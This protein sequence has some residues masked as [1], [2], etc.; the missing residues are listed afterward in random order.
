MS[1]LKIAFSGIKWNFSV[2]M[3]RVIFQLLQISLLTRFL[4]KEDFGLVAMALF[5]VQFS[6]I[7]VDMGMTPAILNRQNSTKN[8]YSSIYWLNIFIALIIYGVLFFTAPL[9]AV[10]YQEPELYNVIPILGVNVLLIAIG[11]QHRAILQKEFKFKL[12]ALIEMFSYFIGLI[13]ALLLVLNDYGLYSLV[14]STLL[15]SFIANSL[16][17]FYNFKL[18]PISLHFKF[19]ETKPFL[20]VGGYSMGSTILDFFSREFD[21]LI[22]GKML[23]TESLGVYSLSKQIVI[24]VISLVNPLVISVL[25]P[26]LASIQNEKEKI[27]SSYL[28]VVR[29]L[30][31]INFPIYLFIIVFSKE[32]LFTVYGSEYTEAYPILSFLAFTYCMSAISNPVGSLQIATGRTDIGFKWT[33]LRA[34]ITPIFIYIGALVNLTMV[35][36][37]YALLSL[38]FIIPLWFIQLRPMAS[39]QLKE[40]INQF[41]KPFLFLI[42]VIIFYY[43]FEENTLSN[44]HFLFFLK[45]FI[46][47]FAYFLWMFL[48]D[49]KE[50]LIF[51]R[52]IIS[53]INKTR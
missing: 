23:G 47:I 17:L 45:F 31:Y 53:A 8:E 16:F 35:S 27:K 42:F 49:K 48:I 26:L 37:N 50:L 33:F 7:F 43:L 38:F 46:L 15:V 34:S 11:L 5:I 40:Y 22:I 29:Y 21:V 20:N 51:Y 19:N 1:L 39:I 32:I 52:T 3:I 24:K 12:I 25:S 36:F 4:P 44:N 10:F 18:N 14:Y 41:Y 28:K 6:N 2:S 9:V 30:A 13:T